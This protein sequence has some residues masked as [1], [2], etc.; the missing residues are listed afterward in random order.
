MKTVQFNI[1]T[2]NETLAN[3]KA[4]CM[5]AKFVEEPGRFIVMFPPGFTVDAA[6]MRFASEGVSKAKA[7]ELLLVVMEKYWKLG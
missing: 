2:L 4:H 1:A 6:Q 7:L 3:V 5:C